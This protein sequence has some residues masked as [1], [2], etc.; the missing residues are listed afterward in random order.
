MNKNNSDPIKTVLTIT[1]GFILIYLITKWNWT[2]LVSFIIG[3]IG[4]FSIYLSK[5]IDLVWM[6]ITWLLSLIVPNILL[7]AIFYLFLF[8]ISLLARLFRKN[9]PLNLK[10]KTSSN[11]KSTNKIFDKSSF[12]H[13]W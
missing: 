8:P 7:G 3:L 1:V 10:N 4:I 13:P 9:D 12:E 2:I 11:F 5:K 6:K